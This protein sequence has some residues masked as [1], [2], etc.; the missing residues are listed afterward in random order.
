MSLANGTTI[1]DPQATKDLRTRNHFKLLKL[2]VEKLDELKSCGQYDFK[3]FASMLA[4]GHLKSEDSKNVGSFRQILFHLGVFS[5]SE[6]EGTVIDKNI[7]DK[8]SRKMTN[9]HVN[10]MKNYLNNQNIVQDMSNGQAKRKAEKELE[11]AKDGYKFLYDAIIEAIEDFPRVKERYEFKR[12]SKG[13]LIWDQERKK[14]ISY[15]DMFP[16][17]YIPKSKPERKRKIE[18][19]KQPLFDSKKSK[20]EGNYFDFDKIDLKKSCLTRKINV[21]LDGNYK[22]S[23]FVTNEVKLRKIRREIS[24]I[25]D[26]LLFNNNKL[27]NVQLDKDDRIISSESYSKKKEG[28]AK[29]YNILNKELENLSKE[30]KRLLNLK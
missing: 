7:I 13:F 17:H 21:H 9:S 30:K 28:L 25:Q 5:E 26:K 27:K 1:Q 14:E 16:G 8:K 18:T 3:Q 10:A 6:V 2:I 11:E 23:L 4:T 24:E 19:E 20:I 22:K 12:N 15:A 29:E